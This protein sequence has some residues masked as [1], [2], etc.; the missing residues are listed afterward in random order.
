MKQLTKRFEAF[1]TMSRQKRSW[2]PQTA[3]SSENEEAVKEMICTQEYVKVMVSV[4]LT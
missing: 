2:R 3:T 4:A 1:G